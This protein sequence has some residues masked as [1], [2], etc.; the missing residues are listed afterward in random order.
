M[1]LSRVSMKLPYFVAVALLGGT[2]FATPIGADDS[3]TQETLGHLSARIEELE[4][5]LHGQGGSGD[6]KNPGA[7]VTAEDLERLRDEVRALRDTRQGSPDEVTQLQEEIR[8]L[9]DEITQLKN[10]NPTLK[11]KEKSGFQSP[12]TSLKK[13]PALESDDETDSVL[14]LLEESAPQD[15]EEG[16][17]GTRDKKKNKELES[18]R[19]TATKHAEEAAPSL[20][21]GN[22]EA[23][24]NE[25]FALY[26]KGAYK[27]AE[28][29]FDYFIKT[30]PNYPLVPQAL[31]WKGET[32]LKRNKHKEAKILF[33]T[34]Y[35][36]KPKGPKAPD[37]LL[38]L[39]E[40]LAMQG[41]KED[42]CTAWLKLKSDFSHMTNE[43][44]SEL[45]ALK[46][47]YGCEKKLP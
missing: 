28:R 19:E 14:K 31:Y 17:K 5:Q 38:R 22:A 34:A 9:R 7:R 18:I 27:E 43:M 11:T 29:A 16:A 15:E 1:N 26:D 33:V 42:A 24:Y 20:P 3:D 37:C 39:G 13:L 2:V 41:R 12:K 36:K 47:K 45:A 30:Y 23:Q 46:K 35:K 40:A 6:D 44:K 25:A 8:T 10:E 32:Y 21:T 4:N